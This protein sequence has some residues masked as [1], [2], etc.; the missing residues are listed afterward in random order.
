VKRT[1]YVGTKQLRR[2]FTRCKIAIRQRLSDFAGVKSDEYFYELVYC[3]LTPQS[4]AVNAAKAVEKLKKTGFYERKIEPAKLL[5]HKDSYIRFHNTK[6]KYLKEAKQQFPQIA[7]ALSNGLSSPDLRKWLVRNVKGLGWKEASH[8]L[9]NIGHRDLAILDRHIL[10]NLKKHNVIQSLPKT[11]TAKKYLAIEE[12]FTEFSRSIR[13]AVD[14]LD[15]L[16]WSRETG[17][18]LK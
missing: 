4:S 2:D 7:A 8:F 3:L 13:I 10:R 15:L 12:Q 18:I 16:F 5:Y 14:E 17:K 1:F 6:G 11:L 9:R